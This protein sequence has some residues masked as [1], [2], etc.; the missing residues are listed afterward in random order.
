MSTRKLLDLKGKKV[1]VAGHR[2]MVGGALV[3]RLAAED[4]QVITIGREDLDLTRQ[5]DV[6]RWIADARPQIVLLAAARAGGIAANLH[7]PAAFL[8]ENLMIEA[9]VVHACH[10]H[11]VERMVFLGSVAAYPA[12][13]ESPIREDALMC[14]R[15]DPAHEPYSVAKIAGIELCKFYGRQY[16]CDFISLIPVNVYGPS[17][18]SDPATSHVVTAIIQKVHL[19]KLRKDR[20]ID[21]WGSGRAK[22]EFLHV[23]DLADAILFLTQHYRSEDPIN[24]GSGEEV[25]IRELTEI[26]CEVAG[27]AGDIRFDASKSEGAMRRL[28]DS[29][30]LKAM[31]WEGARSIRAGIKQIYDELEMRSAA[32]LS[33]RTAV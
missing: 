30:R 33:L 20:S 4:C 16:G 5:S 11:G 17:A 1:W 28:A 8:Y 23:D 32:D 29:S 12:N 31:G 27:F 24:V 7:H 19:A 2:G 3:R 6:E 13:A 15:P 10:K 18:K 26:V 21:I 14:G 22:R 25:S 9:N